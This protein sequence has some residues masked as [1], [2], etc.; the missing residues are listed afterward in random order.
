VLVQGRSVAILANIGITASC[1]YWLHTHDQSGLIHIEAPA[2]EASTVFTLGDFFDVWGQP[3]DA[4]HIASLALAPDQKLDV[5]LDGQ[6]YPGNPRSVPLGAHAQVVL[7]VVPP[8]VV[9]PPD[10]TFPPN[11]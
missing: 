7:E 5:Y 6:P 1:L 10:F 8:A 11:Y 3:L 4:T 2:T 9:P